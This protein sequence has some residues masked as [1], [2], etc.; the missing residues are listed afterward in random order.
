MN[1]ATQRKPF[2]FLAN[3]EVATLYTLR[4]ENGLCVSVTDYGGTITSIWAPDRE[5]AAGDVVLGYD[6]LDGYLVGQYYFGA[7]IGRFGNR[8]NRGKFTLDGVESHSQCKRR[9]A[10]PSRRISRLRQDIVADCSRP[11]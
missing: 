10:S 2:G 1:E 7:L 5:G 8:L 9:P 6:T 4:A 11:E 3:G